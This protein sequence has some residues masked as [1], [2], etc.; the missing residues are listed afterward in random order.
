MRESA[1][2]NTGIMKRQLQ[3]IV[4]R[5]TRS[6]GEEKKGGK[7]QVHRCGYFMHTAV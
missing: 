1:Q 4:S 3:V 6:P 2:E 5:D 7:L